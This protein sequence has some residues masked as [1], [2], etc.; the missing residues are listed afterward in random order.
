MA[1]SPVTHDDEACVMYD[2]FGGL[3]LKF[4]CLQHSISTS[5]AHAVL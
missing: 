4:Q 1:L 3:I 2:G 5:H